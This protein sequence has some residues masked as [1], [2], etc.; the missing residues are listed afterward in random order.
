MRLVG[1]NQPLQMW[2]WFS[3]T[4]RRF[5]IEAALYCICWWIACSRKIFFW[6]AACWT[7]EGDYA[8][9]GATTQD[10]TRGSCIRGCCT[11]ESRLLT[12]QQ[13]EKA[14]AMQCRQWRIHATWLCC[15]SEM[16]V[17]ACRVGIPIQCGVWRSQRSKMQCKSGDEGCIAAG[18]RSRSCCW[19]VDRGR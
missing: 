1:C 3:R 17:S 10:K 2:V 19:I 18:M 5:L 14:T 8:A 4:V 13:V 7:D 9:E 16:K 12:T 11:D 15:V 6:F